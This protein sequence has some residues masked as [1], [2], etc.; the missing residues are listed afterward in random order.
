M[1]FNDIIRIIDFN[2]NLVVEYIYDAYGNII[3]INDE[4]NLNIGTINPF[5]YRSY[6]YDTETNWYY[7]N[8]RYYNPKLGR[9]VTMDEVEY[10]GA[11]GSL[12]SYNLYSYCEGN[13]IVRVDDSR[14]L[15]W[16]IIPV[17]ICFLGM[18]GCSDTNYGCAKKYVYFSSQKY[19]CYAYALG[20]KNWTY[21]GFDREKCIG[22]SV[23]KIANQVIQDLKKLGR[24]GRI[25]ENY[26]SKIESNEYRIAIRVT[27]DDM[28]KLIGTYDYHFMVQ[29]NNGTWSHK[30]GKS[31]TVLL[32]KGQTPDDDNAWAYYYNSK[33]VYMAIT[34]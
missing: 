2:S 21:V 18:S 31:P 6:Y 25:I 17:T 10:L 26:D 22:Y 5:R 28:V 24:K 19:N 33:T 1:Y 16:I 7:L 32:E 20:L 30:P 11:S 15:W 3:N 29:Y 23:T 13:P 8:S 12:L 4:S 34:R 9:F 14:R 27:K